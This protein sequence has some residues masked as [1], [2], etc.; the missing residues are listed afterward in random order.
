MGNYTPVCYYDVTTYS[1]PNP[2]ECDILSAC[3]NVDAS[4]ISKRY[5]NS[6][7]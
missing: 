7:C 3:K 5:D 4:Q 6:N 2:H 1:Y